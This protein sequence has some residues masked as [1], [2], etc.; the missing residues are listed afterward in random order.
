MA[1]VS[2][3][4]LARHRIKIIPLVTAACA[5]TLHS[6]FQAKTDCTHKSL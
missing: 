3:V 2:W 5:Q 6:H 4:L 1:G